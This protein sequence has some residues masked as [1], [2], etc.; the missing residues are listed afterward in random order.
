MIDNNKQMADAAEMAQFR[1]ALIAPVI[2]NLYTDSS[3]TAYY[4]RITKDPLTFPDGSVKKISYRTVEKWVS[5]YSRFGIDGITPRSRDDKGST[6]ALNDAAI[7]EIY[8][9]K[10][11]F[12]RLNAPQ[13]YN[14][15]IYG[16]FIPATVNVSAV[17][18]FIKKDDLKGARNLTEY[19][20]AYN[21]TMHSGIGCTPLDRYEK[22]REISESLNPWNGL[23]NP[24]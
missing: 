24:F 8:R 21:T 14:Q 22:T 18:R 23:R 9:L 13:I 10:K 7:E 2:H 17:Q 16:G 20:R 12:P 3:R 6:R 19:I 5:L 11:E 1:F 4:K 15:L